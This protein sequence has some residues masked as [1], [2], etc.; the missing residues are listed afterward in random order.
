MN[1]VCALSFSLHE[2]RENESAHLRRYKKTPQF[3]CLRMV[4]IHMIIFFRWGIILGGN[5]REVVEMAGER[6]NSKG[7]FT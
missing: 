7:I 5:L 3:F 2:G 6:E 4:I 1:R